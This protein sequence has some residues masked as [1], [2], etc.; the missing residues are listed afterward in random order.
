MNKK[1]ISKLVLAATMGLAFFALA[2]SAQLNIDLSSQTTFAPF[3]GG[4]NNNVTDN[5]AFNT[6]EVVT[7]GTPTASPFSITFTPFVGTQTLNLVTDTLNTSTLTF[8]STLSPLNYFTSLG[9]TREFDF[10]NDGINDLTQN[11]TIN[12]NPFTSPNGL[13]GVS[14]NIVPQNY[15]GDVTINGVT[16][17]YASVVANS[18][19]TLFDGSTSTALIQFQFIATPVP[20][21]STYALA[22]VLA[23]GCVVVLRRRRSIALPALLS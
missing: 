20:E 16:Y 5:G 19:G 12:L 18:V 11:Y 7:T 22:G 23:L 6:V 17:G 14:Y 13:T 3:T 8:R 15:F 2:A 10:D 9:V 4:T 21:P 1:S